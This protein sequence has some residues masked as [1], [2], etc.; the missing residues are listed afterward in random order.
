MS[1]FRAYGD[2]V[3][4]GEAETIVGRFTYPAFITY[5]EVRHDQGAFPGCPLCARELTRPF[6]Q[7]DGRCIQAS[8]Q[9]SNGFSDAIIDPV[10][11]THVV[12][13]CRRCIVHFTTPRVAP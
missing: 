5:D 10:P 1:T 6:P 13:F 7:P 8:A 2:Y 3:G 11:A 4:P 9:K 12:L